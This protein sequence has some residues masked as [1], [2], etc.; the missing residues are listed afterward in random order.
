MP[1]KEQAL[2]FYFYAVDMQIFKVEVFMPNLNQKSIIRVYSKIR[3]IISPLGDNLI[4]GNNAMTTIVEIDE[5]K[6][7]KKRKGNKGK[8]FKRYWVFG[9]AERETRKTHFRLV[10]R[11]DRDTLLPIIHEH[12]ANG[13]TIYHDDWASYDTLGDEGFNHGVV[14]HQYEFKSI[15]GVCTNTIEGNCGKIV[16]GSLL[17]DLQTTI[18]SI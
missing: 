13:A 6:F 7:G 10:E 8:A 16:K 4:L 18:N 3:A 11:R 14:V 12:V 15:E 9:M 2:L 1:L 17:T 5:S